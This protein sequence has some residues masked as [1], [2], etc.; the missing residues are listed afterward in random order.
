MKNFGRSSIGLAYSFAF[1]LS[2]SLLIASCGKKNQDSENVKTAVPPMSIQSCSQGTFQTPG[3]APY[4]GIP[5]NPYQWNGNYSVPQAGFC[6]C[7]FGEVPACSPGIGMYCVPA[8]QNGMSYAQYNYN[9]GNFNFN[10]Y[11]TYNRSF[12]NGTC[13]PNIAQMCQVGVIGSCGF[14]RC[15]QTIPGNQYGICA[16]Y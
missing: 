1:A 9:G 13:T 15:V 4:S 10:S 14:G 3:Y 7:N 5:Y 16:N 8:G 12:S 6:G 11:G 2:L